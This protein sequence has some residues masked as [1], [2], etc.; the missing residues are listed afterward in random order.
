MVADAGQ[1]QCRRNSGCIQIE[2][3]LLTVL[4]DSYLKYQIV[5]FDLAKMQGSN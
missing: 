3:F 1:V 5:D 4:E 2:E